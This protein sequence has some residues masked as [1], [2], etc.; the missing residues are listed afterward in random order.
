MITLPIPTQLIFVLLT[1]ERRRLRQ[2]LTRER[3]ARESLARWFHHYEQCE[4]CRQNGAPCRWLGK[5]AYETA[6][7]ALNE[8]ELG[9]ETCG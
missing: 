4:I 7:L 8:V 9:T 1:E 5:D 2:T 3:V 6:L